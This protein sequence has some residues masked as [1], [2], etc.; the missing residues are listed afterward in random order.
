VGVT[1]RGN[2]MVI[3]LHQLEFCIRKDLDQKSPRTMAV[4]DPLMV[5][6]TN[7]EEEEVR[8]VEAPLFPSDPSKGTQTYTLSKR[9]FIERSDFKASAPQNFFGL[10][11]KQMAILKYGFMICL[12]KIFY[13]DGSSISVEEEIKEFDEEKEISHLECRYVTESATKVKGILHWVSEKASFPAEIRLYD[14][15]FH[16][17]NP[18]AAQNWKEGLDIPNSLKIIPKALISSNLKNAQILDKFQF[19]RLGYFCVDYD[20][21][22]ST[23]KYVFNRTVTLV[24]SK[25]KK[26]IKKGKK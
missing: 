9:L 20:S 1:R 19:E 26:N 25:E 22:I 15:L 3:P 13:K 23:G 14:L 17:E 24:E 11:G 12:E 5:V 6:I 18:K 16:S 10:T 2:E 8:E 21:D 4:L 7:M